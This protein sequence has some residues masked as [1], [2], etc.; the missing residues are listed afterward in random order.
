M[1]RPSLRT[2]ERVQAIIDRVRLG[3]TLKAACKTENVSD[4]TMREWR[5]GDEELETNIF[6]AR[7]AGI[8]PKLEEAEDALRNAKDR[9][10][11]IIADKIA[12]H[13]RWLA[14]KLLAVFQPI[15]KSEVEHTGPVVIGWQPRLDVVEQPAL[16]IDHASPG[17]SSGAVELGSDG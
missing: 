14:E 11:A 15:Q 9:D 2:P 16:V 5:Q 13:T 6:N 4:R 1:G 7:L 12:N 10:A 3:A 17:Q 8:W